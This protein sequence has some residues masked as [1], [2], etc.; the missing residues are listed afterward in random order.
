MVV[1]KFPGA[2]TL[3]VTEGIEAALDTLQPGLQGISVDT[4]LFRQATYVDQARDN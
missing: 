2:N 3:E 4:S 1:E